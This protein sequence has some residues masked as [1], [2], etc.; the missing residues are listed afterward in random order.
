[1]TESIYILTMLYAIYVVDDIEGA[2]Y[3]V[4]LRD[5]FHINLVPIHQ[6]Y[7]NLRDGLIKAVTSVIPDKFKATT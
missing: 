4:Y 3:V 7:R 6:Q 5:N 1:M 2:G